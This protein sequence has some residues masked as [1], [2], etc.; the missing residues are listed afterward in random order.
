MER[1]PVKLGNNVGG[2]LCH[3]VRRGRGGTAMSGQI[4]GDGFNIGEKMAYRLPVGLAACEAV[5]KQEWVV[6]TASVGAALVWLTHT[7]RLYLLV[8]NDV[9]GLIPACWP[10]R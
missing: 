7:R 2:G 3:R 10:N 9:N 1:L 8:T 5:E 6:A 4:G